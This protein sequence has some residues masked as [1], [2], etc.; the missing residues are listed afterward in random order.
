MKDKPPKQKLECEKCSIRPMGIFCA[1][2]H[3]SLVELSHH[4]VVNT[5]KKGQT[6]FYEGNKSLGLFCIFSGK[7]K[8][9]KTGLDGRQ[10]IVRIAG[11][12]DLL[13]YRAILANELYHA[14]AEAMEDAMICC[15]DREAFF[16]VLNKNPQLSLDIIKKLAKELRTAEDL[17]TS[18]AQKS[19]RER[20]AELLLILK[21]SYG[22]P[23][24]KGLMIDLRLTREEMAEMIGATQETAIRLI[25]D[26]RKEGIIEVKDR[27]ITLL[28]IPAL[29]EI[30]NLGV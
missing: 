12:G 11:P 25:S 29:I 7:V 1:L 24:K 15:I 26:F 17:A 27:E 10:Q 14:S 16:P 4:K 21:E 19:V 22:K 8:L 9:C 23:T 3:G 2:E 13:G 20:M 5:Y 18:I 30:A 6:V 28:D